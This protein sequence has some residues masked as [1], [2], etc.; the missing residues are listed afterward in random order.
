[1][2]LRIQSTDLQTAYGCI[3]IKSWV[4]LHAELAPI[5]LL[6]DSLG[7][8]DLWRDFPLLLSEKTGRTVHAYDRAGF[9]RSSAASQ[10]PNLDFIAAES[11]TVFAAVAASLALGH[12]IVMGH[13]VGG[14]M[15]ACIAADYAD[16]CRGLI[17]ISAQSMLEDLTVLGIQE[18][19]QGFAQPGQLDRLAKY[20]GDK[21]QWVLDAWTETWCDPMFAD[22]DLAEYLERVY[23][24]NLVLHGE[25][26]EYGS[27]IQAERFAELTQG[28][29]ALYILSGLHHMPHKENPEL[30]VNLIA[31]FLEPLE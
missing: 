10:R 11:Q 29:S 13:S 21:A 6:H 26:D 3:Y 22:W 30:A 12:F 5:I 24:P 14:G 19:K 7:S 9:G 31:E 8:V 1:M 2:T 16:Q 25:L 15:S 23:C 20:H 17:T 4:Q 27:S 28:P 18:A